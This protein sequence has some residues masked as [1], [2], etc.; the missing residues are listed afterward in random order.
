MA[1]QTANPTSDISTSGTWSG[2]AGSRYT[3]VDDYP[4]TSTADR[5]VHGTTAG[6][7]IF[8]YTAFSVPSGSTIN[9]IQVEYYDQCTF[10]NVSNFGGRIR[11]GGT[12]YDVSTHLVSNVATSRTDT[13]ST[14]PRTGVAWTVDDVNGVGS[15]A[16]DAFGVRSTD[17]NPQNWI[18]SIRLLVDYTEASTGTPR[19]FGIII[20]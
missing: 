6:S 9:S 14:N 8:G 17:A 2:T 10:A 7:I 20:G 16:L 13:W 3:L 4:S 11:V 1:T 12:T 18:A 15:D 19:S 5:L